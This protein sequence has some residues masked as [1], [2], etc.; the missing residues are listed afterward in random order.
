MDEPDPAPVTMAVL[1]ASD[2][3]MRQ[4]V[5]LK[6]AHGRRGSSPKRVA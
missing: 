6:T 4:T 5:G 2:S 3:A 1:P